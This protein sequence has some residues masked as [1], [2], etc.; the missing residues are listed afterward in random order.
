MI[1]AKTIVE[2]ITREDMPNASMRQI[3]DDFGK[4]VAVKMLREYGGIPITPPKRGFLRYANRKIK[5]EFNGEN[6]HDMIRK[7]DVSMSH[8]YS[9]AREKESEE[10][11]S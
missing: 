3:W 10:V 11:S 6:L 2:D 9:I 4:E 8:V 1:S 5:E 7:Y